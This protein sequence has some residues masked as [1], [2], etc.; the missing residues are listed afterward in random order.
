MIISTLW[1]TVFHFTLILTRYLRRM[2]TASLLVEVWAIV[3]NGQ[4]DVEGFFHCEVFC[5]NDEQS[6]SAYEEFVCSFCVSHIILYRLQVIV[7]IICK[8]MSGPLGISFKA[9]ILVMFSSNY[10]T[11]Q[12]KIK[13]E[14]D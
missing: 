12:H 2:R 6:I 3:M 1:N 13:E 5:C 7:Y 4:V 9:T 10:F 8:C 14:N 11:N